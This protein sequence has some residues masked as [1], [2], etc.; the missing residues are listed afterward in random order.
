MISYEPLKKTLKAKNL[1]K[2]YL[3]KHGISKGTIDRMNKNGYISLYTVEK[4]C[5]ILDCDMTG[6]VSISIKKSK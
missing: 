1:T 6:V 2:Y 5:A 3:I 4:I